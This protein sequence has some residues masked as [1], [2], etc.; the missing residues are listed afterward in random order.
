MDKKL[1]PYSVH[2]PEE[3]FLKIKEA[4]DNRKASGLVREAIISFI[5]N[6]GLFEKGFNSGIDACVKSV[7]KHKLAGS[8]AVNGESLSE[9][10]SNELNRLAK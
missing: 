6:K 7:K 1:I 5:E 3:I 8:L 9:S 10:I 2:L 4:A